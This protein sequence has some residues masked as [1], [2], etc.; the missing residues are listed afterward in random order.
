MKYRS[1]LHFLQVQHYRFEINAGFT[2]LNKTERFFAYLMLA[3]MVFFVARYSYSFGSQF[4][5]SLLLAASN[6]HK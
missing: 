3:I 4:T 1:F 6:S 5:Q 2:V